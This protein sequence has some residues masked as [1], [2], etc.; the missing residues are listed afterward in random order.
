M[1]RDWSSAN[2]DRKREYDAAR[3]L[4]QPDVLKAA[5]DKW[6]SENRTQRLAT[7][8][9]SNALR[10]ERIKRQKI[11]KVYAKQTAK[12]YA[13]CPAGHHVDHIVPLR[14]SSVSGLHVPWNLQYLP[15]A[16]NLKKGNKWA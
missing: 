4:G 8:K 7:V 2:K 14:G 11:A 5:Y 9:A 13:A 10:K 16:E 6:V 3:R 15:A 1:C 12:V